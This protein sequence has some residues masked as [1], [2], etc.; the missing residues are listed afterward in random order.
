MNNYQTIEINSNFVIKVRP[1]ARGF[2]L[3]DHEKILIENIWRYEESHHPKL[4]NGQ[5]LN[6]ISVDAQKMEGEFVDYKYYIAQLRDPSFR[7]VL[8]IK[9]LSVSGITSSGNKILVGQRSK[10][11][12]ECPEFYELVPSGGFDPTSVRDGHIDILKQFQT[13]LW[14]ESGISASEVKDF[15]LLKLVYD[16]DNRNYEICAKLHINYTI[17]REELQP[18]EEYAKLMWISKEEMGNFI[19]KNKSQFVPFSLYLLS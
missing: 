9:P 6:V 16:P 13:E 7:Q 17:L 15:N 19:N 5:F 18:S 2:E 3:S 8:D 4:F 14:E 11:V 12:T 10:H 1:Y